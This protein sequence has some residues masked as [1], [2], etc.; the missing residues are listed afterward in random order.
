MN[1]ITLSDAH[2]RTLA[3]LIAMAE[4]HNCCIRFGVNNN[5][6]IDVNWN[7]FKKDTGLNDSDVDAL[8]IDLGITSEHSTSQQYY[9][10]L[11]DKTNNTYNILSLIN[12]ETYFTYDPLDCYDAD[13]SDNVLEWFENNEYD[14]YYSASVE[15]QKI[16]GFANIDTSFVNV[17]RE[18][19]L[20]KFFGD[21][22]CDYLGEERIKECY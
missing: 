4:K 17:Y 16:R 10:E 1:N 3:K 21:L 20:L 5:S 7:L 8:Q 12:E 15:Y 11:C 18:G 2:V 13:F 19:M 14:G 22:V 6:S 9:Y